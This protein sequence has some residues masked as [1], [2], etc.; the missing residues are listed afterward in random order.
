MLSGEI[1]N[2][3]ERLTEPA[4]NSSAVYAKLHWVTSRKGDGWV[5]GA[6][7]T[8]GDL[9]FACWFF[10]PVF[11]LC[12]EYFKLSLVLEKLQGS[13]GII[14]L[15]SKFSKI[16]YQA[17]SFVAYRGFYTL[18]QKRE[19]L[20]Y[21]K[22]ESWNSWDILKGWYN[23]KLRIFKVWKFLIQHNGLASAVLSVS[24]RISGKEPEISQYYLDTKS[25]R[26]ITSLSKHRLKAASYKLHHQLSYGRGLLHIKHWR[27]Q[28]K[29]TFLLIIW[30]FC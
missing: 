28:N 1:L 10:G 27:N 25:M 24:T 16:L 6:P 20:F 17:I 13:K 5:S 8:R 30:W 26:V 11:S 9:L 3:I 23:L 21:R 22:V 19:K 18:Q 12:H 4:H 7:H 29:L 2:I 14:K 15:S